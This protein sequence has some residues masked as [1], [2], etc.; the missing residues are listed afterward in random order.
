M[1]LPLDMDAEVSYIYT[2]I[3]FGWPSSVLTRGLFSFL[4]L[5]TVLKS[6]LFIPIIIALA[7]ITKTSKLHFVKHPQFIIAET[8]IINANSANSYFYLLI[9]HRK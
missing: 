1:R 7:F 4:V 3:A 2:F 6:L 8:A 9:L 5:V